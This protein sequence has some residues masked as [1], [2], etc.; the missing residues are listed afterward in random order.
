M[1]GKAGMQG[2]IGEGCSG[3]GRHKERLGGERRGVGE[4]EEGRSL[5][6]GRHLSY[7]CVQIKQT[8]E[9]AGPLGMQAGYPT[10]QQQKIK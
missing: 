9:T 3:N 1:Q 6:G 7:T 4:A 2:I 5:E 10:W 8:T